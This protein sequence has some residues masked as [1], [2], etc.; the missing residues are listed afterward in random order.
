[1]TPLFDTTVST[2]TGDF[3]SYL[4]GYSN[5]FSPN[6]P[7]VQVNPGDTVPIHLSITPSANPGT[8]VSGVINV[9]NL[10]LENPFLDTGFGDGGDQLASIPYSYTVGSRS[11]SAARKAAASVC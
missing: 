1:M 6:Q 10:Y 11:C 9:D 5:D 4:N 7:G 8:V 3:W 2:D